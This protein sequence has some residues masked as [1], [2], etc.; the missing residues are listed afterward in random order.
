MDSKIYQEICSQRRLGASRKRC[1][2]KTRRPS[3]KSARRTSVDPKALLTR[4]EREVLVGI[5]AAASDE[6]IAKELNVTL[7]EVKSD[8]NNIYRKLNVPDRLQA[9]LWA[10]TYL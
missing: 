8:V 1:E 4:R 3:H 10:V 6:Q 9:I 2:H 7:T 5:A